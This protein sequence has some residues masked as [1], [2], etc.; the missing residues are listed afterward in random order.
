MIDIAEYFQ[1]SSPDRWVRTLHQ[2]GVN[3]VV[4]ELERSP[5]GYHDGLTDRPWDMPSLRRV[6]DRYRS[7]DMHVAAVEDWPPM[8]KLRLGLP[9]R[10]EELEWVATL[11]TNLGALGVPM[12]CYNWMAVSNWTRTR[13]RVP[14]R[15]GAWVTGFSASDLVDSPDTWAGKVDSGQLWDAY[16]WFLEQIVPVA[17]AAGVTLAL[18]PDDPPVPLL[19]GVAR[20]M[21]SVP[22]YERVL[23]LSPSPRHC[24]CVCVGNFTLMTD[25]VPAAIRKLGSSGRIA[26]AHLRDVRGQVNDFVEVF[27]DEGPT[28]LLEVMR[29]LRDVEFDGIVRPDHVPALWGEE[30][31]DAGY[32]WLGRLHAVGYLQG[33][34][35][36][37]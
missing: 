26:F 11:L 12:W 9:G 37:L 23:S 1:P 32:T 24:L 34:R 4:T 19:R 5:N 15:G 2:I 31:T 7:L 10:E 36:A 33:L 29:A 18:H 16:A 30:Q 27:H 17:E 8:D 22:A 13:I 35:A 6:V 14:G 3:S 21:I 20:I 25:D 28:D